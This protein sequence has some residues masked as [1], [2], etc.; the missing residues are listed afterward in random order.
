MGER[1]A[2]HGEVEIANDSFGDKGE[3]LLLVTGWRVG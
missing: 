3:P 1:Q 2:R